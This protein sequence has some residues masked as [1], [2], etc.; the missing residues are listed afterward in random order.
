MRDAAATPAVGQQRWW[1][2]AA[3]RRRPEWLTTNLAVLS[4]VSL[5]QDTA[6]ELLYPILPIFLTSVLG[7]PA[8][9]VG[10][11]EGVGNG[12][13]A[14]TTPLSGRLADRRRRRPLVAAGYGL[15]SIGKV[16]VALATVWP[17]VLAGRAVDRVGKGVR[18]APRDALIADGVRPSSRGRAFGFHRMADTVGAVLGPLLGLAAYEAF[19]HRIRLLLWLAVPPAILSAGLVAAVRE[20]ARARRG[21]LPAPPEGGAIP[22]D[23][24]TSPV[25]DPVAI[26]VHPETGPV[27]D[28]VAIPV[29]PEAGPV[30]DPVAIPADPETATAVDRPGRPASPPPLPAG[31]WRL[32]VVLAAFSLINFPDALLLL[33]LRAIGF[34]VSS[35]I[36]AYVTYNLVY[37]A[38]SYPAG[39]LSDRL[40]RGRVFGTGLLFF[41][42]G[43]V[44]LAVAHD[45]VVAW[46]VLAAYGAFTACTDGVGKAWV[47]SLAGSSAQ[48]RAQ[49]WFQGLTGGAVLVAGLWAG[50]A[51]HGS[52]VVPLALA[53]SIAAAFGAFL[54]TTRDP[55][56]A[57]RRSPL[58]FG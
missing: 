10:A 26:P 35:V 40:P 43:Y 57:G 30:A 21:S 46:L 4:G 48:A 28:P 11:V 13:A 58:F 2:R 31:F 6:S 34:S 7:A 23:P 8:A 27:A 3:R 9:V 45:H 18:G 39:A 51:W 17:V 33:R 14:A 54:L 36:L 56:L 47:S 49:G 42:L 22:A 24:E 19:D 20:P 25:A 38:A 52:G 41:A 15:A 16:L 50:L 37:V 29:H 44:G 55:V 1:R 12:L 53:G 5:L 32:T